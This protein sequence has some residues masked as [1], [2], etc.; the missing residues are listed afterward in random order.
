MTM[1]ITD[2]QHRP[3]AAP[4]AAGAHR[5]VAV[6]G[7]SGV[8]RRYGATTAL[9]DVDL[10][11]DAGETVA[12]L[13]PNGAGK[14]TAIGL[15]LGLLPPSSGQVQLLGDD[16]RVAV[17]G[18]RVGAML[19]ESGLPILTRVGELVQ[20]VRGL[21]PRPMPFDDV[22]RRAGLSGLVDRRTE[23]LS[24]GEAQ[25]VRFAMA[26]AGDPDLCSSTN[27]PSRWTSRHGGRSGPTCRRS[28]PRAGRSCSR[29]TTSRRPTR[30]PTGSSFSTADRSSPRAR[31][32]RSRP[33]R[34][35][36]LSGSASPRRTGQRRTGAAL[37]GVTGINVAG[38]RV[39][40]ESADPDVTARAL[41]R[42]D[43]DVRDLEI[44]GPNLESAFLALTGDQAREE[45]A[46][47]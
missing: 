40:L 18:G 36:G 5:G 21:S 45:A 38:D 24:G 34:V 29:R 35:V 3:V 23:S 14:S 32:R 1:T 11:I 25:R 42:S 13:G 12:L 43:L 15:M 41:L 33:R 7:F 17:R 47:S 44:A 19:Q 9:R 20:L 4:L 10:R 30:S 26:I 22:I 39:V 16:P 27:R 31:P 28:P 2:P 6:V 46:R 8:T 37:P